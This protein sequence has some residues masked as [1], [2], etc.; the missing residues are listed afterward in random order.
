M[1]SVIG[2]AR[3][4]IFLLSA[5]FTICYQSI[6]LFFTKGRFAYIYPRAYHAFLCRLFGIRII[7]EGDIE[8]EGRVVYV[9]NHISYLDI[10]VIGSVLTGS[11]VAKKEVESWPIFGILG[12]MQRTLYIS[13]SPKDARRE[14]DTM[15]ERLEENIP[16]IIFP[17]GTSSNGINV[18]PFKSSFFEILLNRNIKIQPFTI[19]VL[20]VDGNPVKTAAIR[21]QYT[22]YG[23]MTLEPHLWAFA[24]GE[25]AVVKVSLQKPV[26]SNEFSDRK[27]LSAAC[28]TGVVKGL[29]LSPAAA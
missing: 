28:H 3:L 7:V 17:E 22:W 9:G 12:K 21:D 11:F 10:E 25:G 16:L 20:E 15:L 23:D 24:K 8:T 13:R 27:T 2:A 29:D 4:F 5:I 19:S 14:T 26:L 1:R 18:L 6:V